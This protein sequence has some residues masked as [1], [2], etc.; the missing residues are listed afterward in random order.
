MEGPPGYEDGRAGP[1]LLECT[2]P[3][4]LAVVRAIRPGKDSP[5]KAA[6]CAAP[7]LHDLTCR[8]GGF[9]L[10]RARITAMEQ[11]S[12]LSADMVGYLVGAVR[13][14]IRKHEKEI[15][16]FRPRPGQTPEAYEEILAKFKNGQAYRRRVLDRLEA[17]RGRV[18]A[19]SGDG[20]QKAPRLPCGHDTSVHQVSDSVSCLDL[21]LTGV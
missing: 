16:R 5:L 9:L 1:R 4:S 8:A 19:E 20:Y 11:R 17:M 3:G 14:Q 18:M 12:E 7:R 10:S 13:S 15:S 6:A 21:G 2:H